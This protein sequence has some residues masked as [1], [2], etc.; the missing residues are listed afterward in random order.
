MYP[1][2]SA[3]FLPSY[4]E[5]RDTPPNPDRAISSPTLTG[6][7]LFPR[8]L[9]TTPGPSLFPVRNALPPVPSGFSQASAEMPSSQKPFQW[10]IHTL[11]SSFLSRTHIAA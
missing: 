6:I 8:H 3:G 5:V 2:H 7:S 10:P 1:D 11:F 9:P 4:G